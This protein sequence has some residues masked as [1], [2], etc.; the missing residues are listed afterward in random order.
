[1]S[2]SIVHPSAVVY[3]NVDLGR[4]SR[5]GEFCV[6]GSVTGDPLVIGE[7]SVIRSH[8]II[9]G[10]SEYGPGLETGH[11]VLLR[12]GNVAGLNLRIGSYSSLEGGAVIGDYVRIHGRCEATAVELRHFARVYGGTYLT[13]NRLP[14]SSLKDPCVVD[15]GAVICMGVILIAGVTVGVGAFVGAGLVVSKDVPPGTALTRDGRERPVSELEV[16]DVRHPW[17]E[18]YWPGDYPASAL[19]RFMAMQKKVRAAVDET[20]AFYPSLKGYARRKP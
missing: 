9:Y 3:P 7:G 17:V 4:G 6:L 1:M 15:E 12:S 2:G 8:S 5:V 20:W 13:D 14:P 11:H 10:G 16:G 19:E 18:H